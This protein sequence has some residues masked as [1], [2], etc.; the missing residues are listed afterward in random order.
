MRL[1]QW[2]VPLTL[3]LL[4]LRR[5]NRVIEQ[6]VRDPPKTSYPHAT[7]PPTTKRKPTQIRLSKGMPYPNPFR[8]IV[9]KNYVLTDNPVTIEC[10]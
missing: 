6:Y 2:D 10:F 4:L 7:H 5:I 8:Y 3:L 1:N 9:V